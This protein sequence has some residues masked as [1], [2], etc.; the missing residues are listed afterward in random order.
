M[1]SAYPATLETEPPERFER[2]HVALRVVILLMLSLVASV[3]G[4][5]GIVYLA[6]PVVAAVVIGQKGGARYIEEDG[7]RMA[8]AVT[9]VIGALAYLSL[10]TD[11]IPG[12]RDGP[13][14][15]A[16]Q[17]AGTPTVGSALLRILTAI[18]SAL[19]L[20]LLG[21]VAGVVWIVAAVWILVSETYPHELYGFL[22]AVVRWETRLL[23]YLA[24]L[25]EPYPP[26]SVDTGPTA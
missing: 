25:V 6:V 12:E 18:P 1:T 17:P 10:L 16:V 13:V 8:R 26:F 15:V 4:L 9:W 22:R 3:P 21:L 11:R 23:A 20:A 19:V 5:L 7:Q 14:R 2:A 24:S